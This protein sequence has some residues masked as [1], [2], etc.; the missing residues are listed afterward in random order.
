MRQNAFDPTQ[1]GKYDLFEYMKIMCNIKRIT[2][3]IF[4]EKYQGLK[5]VV[6]GYRIIHYEYLKF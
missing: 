4:I 5:K 2:Y 6:K 1:S 3:Q